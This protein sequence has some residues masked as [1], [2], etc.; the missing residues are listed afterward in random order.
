MTRTKTMKKQPDEAA[1]IREPENERHDLAL[2]G[3]GTPVRCRTGCK[4]EC[5]AG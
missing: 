4:Q 3:R 5:P 1:A 2:H